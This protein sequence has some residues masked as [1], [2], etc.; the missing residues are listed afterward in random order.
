MLHTFSSLNSVFPYFL[1]K[2]INLYQFL[3]LLVLNNPTLYLAFQPYRTNIIFS[4]FICISSKNFVEFIQIQRSLFLLNFN[5]LL[6]FL[7]LVILDGKRV[8]F[9]LLKWWLFSIW[10]W[11]E[12]FW[13]WKYSWFFFVSCFGSI[14]KLLFRILVNNRT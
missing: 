3:T 7:F 1:Q 6:F 10:N 5:F 14:R 8:D 9:N 12:C 11:I 13:V 2:F 4:R